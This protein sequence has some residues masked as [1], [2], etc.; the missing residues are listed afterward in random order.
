MYQKALNIIKCFFYIYIL[1]NFTYL[2]KN[3]NT[4]KTVRNISE[5]LLKEK[6]S[7][8]YG[9]AFSVSDTE[10]VDRYLAKLKKTHH[11]AGHFCYAYKIG[12][13]DRYYRINDD[14]EPR[15]SAG[16]P[17]YGQ[18]NAFEL[19]NILIV[20]V[21]YFGG[22]KLGVGGLISAYK[23]C[24]KK[25]LENNTIITNSIKIIIKIKFN[26]SE[27]NNV[28]RIIKDFKIK[29]KNKIMKD[30]CIF[31]LITNKENNILIIEKIN[32]FRNIEI[33]NNT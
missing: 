16:A 4:Y 9:Y 28:M 18:I 24:A 30:I 29:I 33:L 11:S 26:Y 25:T 31:E 15:N 21:R 1:D 19:T 10:E 3:I 27:I 22:T 32:Q 17:I 2:N 13:E 5:Y 23:E 20:V 12:I 6:K 8:F 7:K 14:G